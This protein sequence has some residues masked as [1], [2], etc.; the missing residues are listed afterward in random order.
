[1][2]KDKYV[3]AQLSIPKYLLSDYS[4]SGKNGKTD[5]LKTAGIDP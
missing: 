5:P 4:I 1:M 2:H 3:F